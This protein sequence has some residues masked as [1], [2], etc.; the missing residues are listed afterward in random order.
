MVSMVGV[1]GGIYTW[2]FII[3]P[4]LAV[5]AYTVVYSYVEFEKERAAGAG[6]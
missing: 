6:G 2:L 1:L 5:A 4:A 3:V